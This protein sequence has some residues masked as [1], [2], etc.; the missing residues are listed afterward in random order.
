MP[1]PDR[2]SPATAAELR[3]ARVKIARQ[4]ELIE[5]LRRGHNAEV[6]R[7]QL[8]ERNMKKV[9]LSRAGTLTIISS[10]LKREK[11][12]TLA[13]MVDSIFVNVEDPTPS[14]SQKYD[15]KHLNKLLESDEPIIPESLFATFDE[16]SEE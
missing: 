9:N 10:S 7:N 11:M 5:Q 15:H 12:I 8:A 16:E 6:A 13:D 1:N 2:M 4:T 3:E 14:K